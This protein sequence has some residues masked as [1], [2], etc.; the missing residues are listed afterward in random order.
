MLQKPRVSR[1]VPAIAPQPEHSEPLRGH[2]VRTAVASLALAGMLMA[3]SAYGQGTGLSSGLLGAIA[4][5]TCPTGERAFYVAYVLQENG[6]FLSSTVCAKPATNGPLR[7]ESIS[8][9]EQKLTKVSQL[10]IVIV[11]IMPH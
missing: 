4:A 9:V 6:K 5:A 1:A 11:N 3:S 7:P 2:K 10:Q 8:A